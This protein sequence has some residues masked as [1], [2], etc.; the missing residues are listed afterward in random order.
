MLYYKDIEND[1]EKLL[2]II[3]SLPKN[4]SNYEMAIKEFSILNLKL[5]SLNIFQECLCTNQVFIKR[6]QIL[7]KF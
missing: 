3:N 4:Q 6:K 7:M 2:L 1:M 5:N